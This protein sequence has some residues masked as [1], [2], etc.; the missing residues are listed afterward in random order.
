MAGIR[1]ECWNTLPR[2]ELERRVQAELR[3]TDLS[4][5]ETQLLDAARERLSHWKAPSQ[6]SKPGVTKMNTDDNT[7]T[8]TETSQQEKL[9]TAATVAGPKPTVKPKAKAPAKAA[10]PKKAAAPAKAKPKAKAKAPAKSKAKPKAKGKVKAAKVS[11][12]GD[13]VFVA[14]SGW[15]P[16]LREGSAARDRVMTALKMSGKTRAQ[17]NERVGRASTLAWILRNGGGSLR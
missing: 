1:L 15:E 3:R 6:R 11:R 16:E 9:E 5:E 17:V 4:F 10:A 8:H 13:Q 14:K 12:N 2:D 7:T